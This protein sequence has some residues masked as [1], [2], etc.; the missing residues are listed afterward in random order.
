[1]NEKNNAM[2]N[3]LSIWHI[4]AGFCLLGGTFFLACGISLAVFQMLYHENTHNGWL[5]AAA[6]VLWIFG[7]HCLDK[8]EESEKAFRLTRVSL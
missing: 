5:F 7:S 3:A 1:M 4:G 2:S 8:I 6:L